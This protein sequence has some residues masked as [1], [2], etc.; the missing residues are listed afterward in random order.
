[1]AIDLNKLLEDIRNPDEDMVVLALRTL[2]RV[3]GP[4]LANTPAVAARLI[5]ELERLIDESSDEV[6]FF[7]QEC[8]DFVREQMPESAVAAPAQ[9]PSAAPV[10]E[11]ASASAGL[12][13][14]ETVLAFLS[15]GVGD[16]QKAAAALAALAKVVRAEDTALVRKYLRH[17]APTVRVQATATIAAA[18]DERLI[19]ESLLPYLNDRVP[20]VR[21]A[22]MK[23]IRSIDHQRLMTV[24][25]TMLR[26][27]QIN[28]K[29]AAVYI[30]AHLQG[31]EVVRLLGV[32]ARDQHEEVRSR[33]VDALHGR[34][35]KEV[36]VI[37]KGL[38]N[39]MDIDVA[40]KALKI[41]EKLKFEEGILNSSAELGDIIMEKLREISMED[42]AAETASADSEPVPAMPT[43][44]EQRIPVGTAQQQPAMQEY[45]VPKNPVRKTR[46]TPTPEPEVEVV[47]AEPNS[48]APDDGQFKRLS[49]YPE[50]IQAMSEEV[51]DQ[52]DELLE[53]MGRT[54]WKLEKANRIA[55]SRF[56]KLN[57]DIQRYEDM[58][59]K[60]TDQQGSEGFCAKL[61][62]GNRRLQEKQQLN[63]EFSLSELYRRLGEVAVEL[64][65]SDE[66]RF[67]ELDSYYRKVNG[68]LEDVRKIKEMHHL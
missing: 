56:S 59:S 1:M 43:S 48:A 52:L 18:G 65:L 10:S 22:V 26:S 42:D 53:E 44:P 67:P 49:E 51:Y 39:D 66:S 13:S 37:L 68:L 3:K 62:A 11:P 33:V 12:E 6:R 14:R 15:R 2:K 23:A 25:E 47:A 60:R 7:A 50:E 8:L 57:Y 32:A 64:S 46:Q 21:D 36:L 35:G 45:V 17:K 58:L 19:L 9:A 28:V 24:I 20:E 55:D 63:L 34:R 29:V 54:I 40:E 30:L 38:V 27:M 5:A 31:D 41:Y 61:S 4:S 16:P